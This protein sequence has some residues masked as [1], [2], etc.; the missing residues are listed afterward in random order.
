MTLR[1]GEY[2]VY[3]E[4]RNTRNYSTH[5]I[6]VLRGEAP[7][8]ETVLHLELTGDCGPDLKGK[9]FRFQ[10]GK[11]DNSG[12]H[13]VAEENT[14]IR[15]MQFG[16]TGTMTAQGWVRTLPSSVEEFLHRSKLGEPPPTPWKRHLYLEWY[17]PNGRTTIE[18]ADA[19]VE[20]CI[21]QPENDDDE[22]DWIP[23]PNLA[24]VP[25]AADMERPS[26][27]D[28]TIFRRD[29][30]DVH[31]E[32]WTPPPAPERGEHGYESVPDDLQ[33]TLD[34]ESAAIDRA[35]CG[36][37]G[38]DEDG[39]TAELELMDYCLDHSEARSAASL[40]PDAGELPSPETLSDD[41]VEDRLKGLLTQLAMINITL[42]V[43]E[44]FTPRDCYCLLVNTLL[45]EK[46]AYEELI[47]TGWRQH[48]STWEHCPDCEA[49]VQETM[50]DMEEE[51][52]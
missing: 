43:C 19:V 36:E 49:E 50:P 52:S 26:N 16:P 29:G 48:F 10:P 24:D 33:R 39:G 13:F 7:G 34:R 35:I 14:G 4:L 21:R 44:H 42:D 46:S 25:D 22:G 8:E 31:I 5:G 3:G 12:V 15:D 9:H 51:E 45:E 17:G 2:L 20:E 38:S 18:M 30:D 32:H 27:P 11:A 1:L 6:A 37:D 28:F 40:L 41:E 47:G 23:V